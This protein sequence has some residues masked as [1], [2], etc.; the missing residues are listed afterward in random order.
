MNA[1]KSSFRFNLRFLANTTCVW[2]FVWFQIF[3]IYS[4]LNLS[5]VWIAFFTSAIS[6]PLLMSLLQDTVEIGPFETSK[7][8]YTQ[9]N[10][11]HKHH[12]TLNEVFFFFLLSSFF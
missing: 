1:I 3:G 6:I 2:L 11:N 4:F 5:E 7:D 9:L 10:Y 12:G 8:S